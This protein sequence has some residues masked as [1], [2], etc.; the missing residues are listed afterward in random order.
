MSTATAPTQAPTRTS[1]EHGAYRAWLC[2]EAG[3]DWVAR[4]VDQLGAWL[5]R[6][7][8]RLDIDLSRDGTYPVAGKTL[9][10]RRHTN[11]GQGAFRFSMVEGL[12]GAQFT[13]T[14][15][16]VTGRTGGWMSLQVTNDGGQWV[17]TP[18][19]ATN[20][21][22]SPGGFTDG[23]QVVSPDLWH[24][25]TAEDRVALLDLLVS[26]RRG[27]VFVA[28][29]GNQDPDLAADFARKI[30]EWTSGARGLA[31]LVFLDADSAAWL[32][33]QV[34]G[35]LG[36][37]E[38]SV[39]TFRPGID[40]SSP[41]TLRMHRTMG[42]RALIDT[43][44]HRLRRLFSMFARQLLDEQPEPSEVLAW[45]R[46]FERLDSREAAEG[47]RRVAERAG[48]TRARVEHSR[49]LFAAQRAAQ[50]AEPPVHAPPTVAEPAAPAQDAP[51]PAELTRLRTEHAA[52]VT[53]R[54]TL[55]GTLR[56]VQ[57]T[58][59]LP[60][61]TE[62]SL[63]ALL[64]AATAVDDD[65]D[66]AAAGAA[67]IETLEGQVAD[68]EAK[69]A[70]HAGAE[71]AARQ[72]ATDTLDQVANLDAAVA[73]LSRQVAVMAAG[74]DPGDVDAAPQD[75][76]AKDPESWQELVEQFGEWEQFGIVITADPDTAADLHE[77]DQEGR[78]LTNTLRGLTA[79]A[80]YVRAK[81]DKV[82][83]GGFKTYLAAQHPGFPHY[84]QD[85][86]ATSET[87]DAMKGD[88]GKERD[89]PVPK[90]ISADGVLEMQQHLRIGRVPN[91]DPR[92]YIHDDT[93][94]TGV[95]VVGYIGPHLT[96]RATAKLNR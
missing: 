41:A 39:R 56:R 96:T 10:V 92:L 1:V 18:K 23:G 16:F 89:L 69:V 3:P 70:E 25:R 78:C 12:P 50:A 54:D 29:A 90:T 81:R 68:L 84:N 75:R 85:W 43:S 33:E 21:L 35:A 77:I 30:E 76:P 5:R 46:T 28:A 42:M 86:F 62:D 82:H 27:A 15:T 51:E 13:T 91:L 2:T 88:R 72:D 93:N 66:A 37:A 65:Q 59:M 67:R 58:L 26:D 44:E 52:T 61:L 17:A 83:D 63:M 11:G 55:L 24:V 94:G 8:R 7:D 31:H 20:L 95:V 47:L 40:L 14:A 32:R 6:K 34:G 79:L 49:S 64:E 74:G 57:D 36:V 45:R 9:T 73:V 48:A 4:A 87:K 19:L 22:V 38:W 53:Q 71:W 60:D 80:G